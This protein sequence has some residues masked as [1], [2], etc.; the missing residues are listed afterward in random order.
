MKLCNITQGLVWASLWH[1]A[2]NS[3]ID[4][5]LNSIYDLS[6]NS[7][8]V[9]NWNLIS[10]SFRDLLETSSMNSMKEEINETL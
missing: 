5:V 10:R 6:Q 9:S 7:V 8:N 4:S 3:I 1:S 2:R